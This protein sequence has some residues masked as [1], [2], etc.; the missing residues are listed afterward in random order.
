MCR[1][2][3]YIFK[4]WKFIKQNYVFVPCVSSKTFEWIKTFNNN[5]KLLFNIKSQSSCLL[6]IHKIHELKTAQPAQN[7]P[8][9][10]ILCHKNCSTHDLYAMSLVSTLELHSEPRARLQ[11]LWCTPQMTFVNH[12]VSNH[13]SHNIA[14]L[15]L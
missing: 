4:K 5:Y 13:Y 7:Q 2:V 3:S 1:F 12:I 14:Y 9:Y 15:Q 6:K 10:Q 8:E 11:F